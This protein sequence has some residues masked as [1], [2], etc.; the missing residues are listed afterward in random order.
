MP[1]FVHRWRSQQGAPAFGGTHCLAATGVANLRFRGGESGASLTVE[2]G[3]VLDSVLVHQHRSA[4]RVHEP[5][6]ALGFGPRAPRRSARVC[7]AVVHA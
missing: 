5:P 1:D 2:H 7:Y 4:T 6:G 3:A